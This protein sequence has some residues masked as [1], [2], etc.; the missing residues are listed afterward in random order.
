[1]NIDIEKSCAV[2][3]HR[4]LGADFDAELVKKAFIEQIRNGKDTFLIGMALGFDTECFKILE[5]LKKEHP[6]IKLIACI[7]CRS[8]PL[9]FSLKQRAE[10]ER[11]INAADERIYVSEE[12]DDKCMFKRNMFM[13]DNASVIIAY[14]NRNS[15]GTF[16]T[17]K[18]A[19]RKRR[20]II[21][22][23]K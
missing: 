16:N 20:K 9:K 18:Y 2:T 17:V 15:G 8:Q 22:I 1:M 12:Y 19:E 23:N 13:V 7:P 10:Y 3:G 21:F 14:L 5:N 11:I 4:I 6:F